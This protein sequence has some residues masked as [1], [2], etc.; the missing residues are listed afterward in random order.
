MALQNSHVDFYVD[1]VVGL[2]SS[3]PLEL[4]PAKSIRKDIDVLRHRV[5]SEGLSFLTKTLP[6]LGKALDQ[7]MAST[8]FS[9]PREFKRS[10]GSPCIPAFMQEYFS[11]VFDKDGFLR[12]D[13]EPFAVKHL[14]QVLLFAYKLELPYES[15]QE[16]QVIDA[17]V[18]T[19]REFER[20]DDIEETALVAASSYVIRTIFE[21]FKPRDVVPRHGPGAVATGEKLEDKW[22]FSRLYKSIHQMYPY[23]EYF[24]VGAARELIDRLDWYKSLERLDHGRAK[25]V[26]VPKD[27]RGPRLISCEPLEYQWI[28]QGLGRSIMRHLESFWMT[29]G[30]VNFTLQS[31]NR[32]HAL[33]SSRSL[34]YAT[35]D[36]KDASDRVT[37]KLVERL[38]VHNDELLRCL[39]ATRTTSTTLPDGRVIMLRKYAPMGS[40]T[41]FP[42]ESVIFYALCVAAIA[43]HERMPLPSAGKLVYVYGDDLVVP[44]RLAQVCMQ[45]L[46]SVHLVVNKQKCCI[47]GPFRESCGMDAFK[48]VQVTP[49]RLRSQ[50]TGRRSD[51]SAYASYIALSNDLAEKGYSSVSYYILRRLYEVYGTIPYSPTHSGVLGIVVTDP[52]H[53]EKMNSRY[54]RNRVSRDYQ[55]VEFLLPTLVSK[56]GDTKLDGWQRLLRDVNQGAGDLPS[57][58]VFPR[59]TR[60]KRRWTS[61]Y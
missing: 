60:I 41:C 24:V 48:G 47:T 12:E 9:V 37:L 20:S 11:L 45:A 39:K 57:S 61:I 59:S 44:T 29:R 7:G 2:I 5:S 18:E 56:Y 19:E 52:E 10:H 16:R 43:R 55:R 27:S 51:G 17:F 31:I 15:L 30:R 21:D 54:F 42:I 38:F 46:E 25:V 53:A 1:L 36:M 22:N 32:E 40:A 14:R 34:E 33:E 13:A 35:L 28:Q 4:T 23:Y 26:L 8:R 49:S 6:K 3:N 58:V 50:W